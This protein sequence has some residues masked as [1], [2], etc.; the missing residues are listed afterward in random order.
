MN[1][2]TNPGQALKFSVS[3]LIPNNDDDDDDDDDDDPNKTTQY[4]SK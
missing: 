4:E 3:E 2:V 1:K